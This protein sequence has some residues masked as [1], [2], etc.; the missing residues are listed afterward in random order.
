M[1]VIVVIDCWQDRHRTG[2]VLQCSATNLPIF[3]FDGGR[4]KPTRV[5]VHAAGI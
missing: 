3:D 5:A 2:E 4:E 1:D